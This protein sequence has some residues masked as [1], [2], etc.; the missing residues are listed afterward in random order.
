MFVAL[1]RLQKP[2]WMLNY[3]GEPHGIRQRKNQKDFAIRMMQF[4]DHFLK[5]APAPEWMSKGIPAIEKGK[6]MRYE[7]ER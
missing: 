1:R 2:A 6:T 5:G 4:F 7:L 3:N